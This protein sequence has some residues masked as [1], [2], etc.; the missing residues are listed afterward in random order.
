[1][2]F[3]PYLAAGDAIRVIA[4]AGVFDRSAFEDGLGYLERRGFEVRITDRIFDAYRYYAGT[5]DERL[6]E[7]NSALGESGTKAIWV[8]RG[9]YGSGRLLS[10]TH[11]S[12]LAQSKWLI[13]FS[14]ITAMH[15]YWQSKGVVSI[16]GAN[17]TTLPTWGDDAREELF[18]LLYGPVG[19]DFR[20]EAVRVAETV[21]APTIGGNLSVIASL[22]GTDLLPSFSGK[23][24]VLEDIGERA[25]RL[26]RMLFQMK[27]A[28]VF[29]GALG[30]AVGQ[31]TRCESGTA[32]YSALNVLTEGL[33]KL[34]I[35]II[36]KVEL[37]HES[38]ARPMLLGALATLNSAEGLLSFGACS[39]IQP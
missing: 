19:M 23:I 22:I 26:D 38:T 24:V 1:M 37:G 16:H 28:G 9:G 34:G 27:A 35:P 29:D 12:D 36:T 5:D 31:L 4:P 32:E 14:D 33:D 7:L 18:S 25:Y 15:L 13:G 17:I 30:V 2:Y 6:A 39:G 10:R 8:A 11:F 21:S 20:G 3:P